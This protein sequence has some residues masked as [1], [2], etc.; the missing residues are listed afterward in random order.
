VLLRDSER[1]VVVDLGCVVLALCGERLTQFVEHE[2]KVVIL[3]EI[4]LALAGSRDDGRSTCLGARIGAG[5]VVHVILVL[6]LVLVV[7]VGRLVE[8]S[9]FVTTA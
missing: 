7:G 4:A 3:H 9:L 6:L 1:V 8:R 5:G 2:H